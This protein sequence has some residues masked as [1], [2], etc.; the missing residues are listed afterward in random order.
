MKKLILALIAAAVLLALAVL[1]AL[2][3]VFGFLIER[4]V[5]ARVAALKTNDALNVQLASYDRGWFS[6][7]AHLALGLAAPQ[8]SAVGAPAP[9]EVVVHL[10]HGP[11]S[12]AGGPFFGFAQ[13]SAVPAPPASGAPTPYAYEFH[14]RT[15]FGGDTQFVADLPAFDRRTRSGTLSFSGGRITG[16]L[17]D[18]RL[19]AYLLAKTARIAGPSETVSLQGIGLSADNEL[20]STHLMP[21]RVE[22]D[23]QRAAVGPEGQDPVLVA[24]GVSLRSKTTVNETAGLM[25]GEL[26]LAADTILSGPEG[27]ITP[28]KFKTVASRRDL[29][30]LR[31]Y[32]QAAVDAAANGLPPDEAARRFAPAVK[33]LL[34]AGPS[35]EIAPLSFEVNGE[36][37][38]AELKA[39]ARP[40]VLQ[41]EDA[42]D[43]GDPAFWLRVL[44]ASANVSAAKS[45]T[46][47]LAAA[48]LVQR[49]AEDPDADP[50]KVEAMARAEASVLLAVLTTQGMLDDA[51]KVYKTALRLEDGKLTVNGKALPVG[52]P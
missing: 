7:T 31:E 4:S 36:P 48:V 51:G 10:R 21:G 33:H 24:A 39:Q 13:F 47:S 6:S 41:Q 42:S 43:I 35:L 16:S 11:V 18:R 1:V 38:E 49:L 46:Q 25:D 34:A 9:A 22:L 27:R 20:L 28:P 5:D 40:G 12:F 23:V 3:P 44:R 2:P 45:L 26:E 50:A 8:S 29:A 15:G 14:G 19:T 30:A 17:Q 32:T 52:R 37:F